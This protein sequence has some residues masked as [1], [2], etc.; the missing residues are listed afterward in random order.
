MKTCILGVFCVAVFSAAWPIAAEE[1]SQPPSGRME[2]M[3]PDDLEA[4]LDSAPVAFVP[5]G[6]YEHHGWL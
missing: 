4:M 3:T 5:L 2:Q 6:T 1:P